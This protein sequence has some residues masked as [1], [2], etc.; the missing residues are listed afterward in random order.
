L[1]LA[2]EFHLDSSERRNPIRIPHPAVIQPASRC[3]ETTDH[4][5]QV[6]SDVVDGIIQIRCSETCLPQ[7]D[8]YCH[9]VA[10]DFAIWVQHCS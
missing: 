4:K 10:A 7:A 6:L 3:N 2:G 1:A 8:D 9:E 5:Q